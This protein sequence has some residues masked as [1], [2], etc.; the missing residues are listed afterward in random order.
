M[1]LSRVIAPLAAAVF[2]FAAQPTFASPL[3]RVDEDDQE[4][5]EALAVY[6]EDK[7]EDALEVATEADKLV[8]LQNLQEDSQDTFKDLLEPYSQDDQEQLFELSRYPDLVESISRGGPKSRGELESLAAKYPE[9]VRNAAVRQ[10]S[11][12]HKVVSRMHALL[13]DFD[14]RFDDLI[15][16]LSPRKQEAFRSMLAT[17]ELLS[18]LA[19]HTNMTVILGDAFDRNPDDLRAALSDLNLEVAKRNAEEADDWKKT[20]DADPDLR[21]D[22]DSAA[23]DY[24]NDT[25]YDAYS[26]PSRPVVNVNISPYPYWVGYPWWYP[27]SYTYYDPWYWWYPRRSWG[28]CGYSYGPRVVFHGGPVYRPWFPSYHFTSW[29]FSGGHH[30]SRYPYLSDRFVS[31]YDRPIVINNHYNY[32]NVRKRVVRKFVYE[33]D[34]V[35]PANYFK[36]K[37][38][39]DRVERFREFGKV[40]PEIEKVRAETRKKEFAGK[41]GKRPGRDFRIREQADE[42]KAAKAEV[43]KLV[44][45]NPKNFPELAKV[46][47]EEWEKPAP[48]RGGKNRVVDESPTFDSGGK[49]KNRQ[50]GGGNDNKKTTLDNPD[51]G[52]KG[53]GKDR[54]RDDTPT[55]EGSNK[56]KAKNKNDEPRVLEREGG[57]NKGKAKVKDQPTFD[58]GGGTKAKTKSREKASPTFQNPSNEGGGGGGGGGGKKKVR[59]D[60]DS[61]NDGGGS[62]TKTRHRETQTFD[63]PSGGGGGV[64]AAAAAAAETSSARSSG[65]TRRRSTRLPSTRR[66]SSAQSSLASTSRSRSRTRVGRRRRRRR[67]WQEQEGPRRR[68]AKRRRWRWRRWWRRR[69]APPQQLESEEGGP[70]PFFRSRA[71][72]C[73]GRSG[74]PARRTRGTPRRVARGDAPPRG[75]PGTRS[76][77]SHRAR[78]RS[79]TARERPARRPRRR[80]AFRGRSGCA[81]IDRDRARRARCAPRG[82]PGGAKRPSGAGRSRRR[83]PR[84]RGARRPA[85]R[86]VRG[87]RRRRPPERRR[88]RSARYR[89]RAQ[90]GR[91]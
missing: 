42:D 87:A 90:P 25:G 49:G 88:P 18:L 44:K 38:R 61:P 85:R 3:D 60:D 84:A 14:R 67:R 11:D 21:R 7:R 63:Q 47:Q 57:G 28:Y 30:H 65:R 41:G 22:Y 12:H 10:G 5:L 13:S 51:S 77:R 56:N 8:D 68:A 71:G 17:P 80:A 4:A 86:P 54:V 46:K 83:R 32:V 16:D 59:S 39:R 53:K 52:G 23:V 75:A 55:F 76:S 9:D 6:P 48:R 72:R 1:L 36:G 37:N 74:R 62:K 29:Y 58:S 45:K 43:Q 35:M 82:S 2:V 70:A 64:V 79:T 33:T 89:S 15:D 73:P 26:G 20:V 69:Q 27:V 19:E 34:H 66:R 81:P 24:R 91:A 50:G 40:A 78:P 31:Y